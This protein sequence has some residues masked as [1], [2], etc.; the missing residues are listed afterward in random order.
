[1]IRKEKHLNKDE[2]EKKLHEVESMVEALRK[3]EI[4]AIIGEENVS[5]VRL[6]EVEERLIEA[7]KL[8]EDRA[9]ELE[10]FSHSISHDLRGPLN[11]IKLCSELLIEDYLEKID[12]AGSDY[13]RRISRSAD[14]M[15]EHISHILNLSK[16]AQH[17]LH[18]IEIDLSALILRIVTELQQSDPDRKVDIKVHDNLTAYGDPKLLEIAMSNLVGNA[19]KFSSMNQQAKIEIGKIDQQDSPVFFVR[20]NGIGFDMDKRQE[21]FKSFKRLHSENKFPGSGVGLSIIK[22]VIDKHEGEIWAEGEPDAGATFYF[23]LPSRT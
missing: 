18:K 16:V 19:W 9:S 12:E 21:L 8:A 2:L 1:M 23:I 20:D 6:R 14:K 3:N 10:D 17:Q 7:R 11:V 4:D 15:N 13:I 22:R 5:L